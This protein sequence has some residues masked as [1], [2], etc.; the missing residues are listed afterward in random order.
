VG[1]L[2]R[3]D[4]SGATDAANGWTLRARVRVRDLADALDASSI[5][6]ASVASRRFRI[7]LGSDA[8]G[9]TLVL[10]EGDASPLIAQA[11]AFQQTGYHELELSWDPTQGAAGEADLFVDGLRVGPDWAGSATLEARILFGADDAAGTGAA[12]YSDLAFETGVQACRNGIDDDGDGRID[13]V[14]GD[15]DPG[16]DSSADA[17]EKGI[18]RL[19]DDGLDNDGDGLVDLADPH[20]SSPVTGRS[21]LAGLQI[22]TSGEAAWAAAAGG[23][24]LTF[25]TTAAN[26]GLA[27]ELGAPPEPGG[28]LCGPPGTPVASCLLSYAAANTQLCRDFGL[29]SL[30]AGGGIT[31]DDSAE[32]GGSAAWQDALSIGDINDYSND[33]FELGFGAGQPVHAFGFHF[34]D[35]QREPYESLRVYGPG[36][37]LI[38]VLPGNAAPLS[39]GNLSA[40]V[41]VVSPV[42]I[43][44]VVF[45]EAADGDDMAIRDLRFGDPDPDSDGLGDCAEANLGTDPGVADSD[46]DGLSDGA[47]VAT[48][49]TDP[50]DADSDDDGLSD[51][52]EVT[53]HAT[54]PND[55]DSDDD[56]LSD[57]AEV[58]THG[59]SPLDPD[60]DD[61]GIPD[62]QEISSGTNPLD[63][64]S[65]DDGLSD[66]AEVGLHGTSPLDAD[67]DDDGL[68]DGQEISSGTNPL[69]ADS[70]DDGLSDGAEVG[71]HGTSPTSADTDADGLGDGAEVN[72]HG[73]NPTAADTDS[74]GLSD[75]AELG[76]HGTSPTNADSDADGLSDG[77]EVNLYGTDPN[78]A[79]GDGDGLSDGEEI[80]LHGSDPA[81]ADSDAD[82]L[83][84]GAE[85][86]THGTD[87]TNADSDGDGLPDGAELNTHGTNPTSADTDGDGLSDGAEIQT[88]GTDPTDP[89][90]DADGLS[91][92]AEI[93]AGTDPGNPDS[94]GDGLGDGPEV[95]T[96]G[97]NPLAPDSDAD[98]LSDGAEV[99]VHATNPLLADTDGDLFADAVEIAAGTDPNDPGSFP[100][101]KVPVMGGL[102]RLVAA[103]LIALAGLRFGR[104]RAAAAR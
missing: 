68:P 13:Q 103:G 76:T 24:T 38:A 64:D 19:C 22:V 36:D 65:D 30:D 21:E 34:V 31:F 25:D 59:T 47:E 79:D 37:E 78:V 3:Q 104:R 10:R 60:S 14:P 12:R 77:D 96:H 90:G 45:D 4:A 92:G 48:H 73:T 61:D 63:A 33:D 83:A 2:Y 72:T 5:L 53:T 82:G 95:S 93:G 80:N 86:N 69:D 28:Q 43:T 56:A 55:A 85:V 102:G 39:D 16:C 46:L 97:T 57:G 8:V 101:P 20:C 66:G 52:A 75:G 6:E 49:A 17:S 98:G 89:D 70:D 91:D 7:A 99:L 42:A 27:T 58:G 40:F 54:D 71:L 94:D 84:D 87:P 50:L 44:R 35:N 62:G 29:R 81:N 18:L 74:D 9:N 88:H 15:A 1:P 32:R 23:Q 26:V 51:G 11:P 67:S 41:G 100:A